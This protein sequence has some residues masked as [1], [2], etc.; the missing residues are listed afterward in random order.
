MLESTP[1]R[2]PLI[3]LSHKWTQ[4]LF[5][6]SNSKLGIWIFSQTRIDVN[7]Q[8]KLYDVLTLHHTR[9]FPKNPQT[10]YLEYIL[11]LVPTEYK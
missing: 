2:I 4:I 6:I 7:T 1:D 10:T 3:E 11:H 9:L 5:I 8:S